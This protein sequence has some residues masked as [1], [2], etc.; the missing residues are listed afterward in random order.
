MTVSTVSAYLSGIFAL[1]LMCAF[2]GIWVWV[3]RPEHRRKFDRLAR[4]PLEDV[5][6]AGRPPAA[7]ASDPTQPQRAMPPTA[8]RSAP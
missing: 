4:V 2:V 3:W 6:G 8:G 1:A 7:Q 5:G